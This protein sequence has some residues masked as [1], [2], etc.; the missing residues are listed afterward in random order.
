M[1]LPLPL[2]GLGGRPLGLLGAERSS[3]AVPVPAVDPRPLPAGRSIT[4][5]LVADPGRMGP[6]R[7]DGVPARG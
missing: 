7:L 5:V 3:T 1:R 6:P 4:A 2:R